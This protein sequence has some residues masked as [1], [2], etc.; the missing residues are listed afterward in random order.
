MNPQRNLPETPLSRRRKLI[1]TVAVS[2]AAIP[3]LVLAVM[4]GAGR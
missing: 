3:Y 4:A 2:F 1:L